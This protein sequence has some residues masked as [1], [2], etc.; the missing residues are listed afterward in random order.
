[1]NPNAVVAL[2]IL[3]GGGALVGIF[4]VLA[5]SAMGRAISDA[6]RHR[7]GAG[8][9]AALRE[10]LESMRSDIERLGGDVET[11]Q[12][13]LTDTQDRLGFAERLLT[14]RREPE[15]LQS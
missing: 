2:A 5:N 15:Q 1:M 7:S 13:Q 9:D 6:I 12:A 8:E 4:A 10:D 14:R 3:T 11:L